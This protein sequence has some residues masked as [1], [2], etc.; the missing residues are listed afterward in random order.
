MSDKCEWGPHGPDGPCVKTYEW[1]DI[2]HPVP[3][4]KEYKGNENLTLDDEHWCPP[5]DHGRHTCPPKNCGCET[6]SYFSCRFTDVLK[7]YLDMAEKY[8]NATSYQERK[9]CEEEMRELKAKLDMIWKQLD[10]RLDQN[11]SELRYLSQKVT[12][13]IGRFQTMANAFADLEKAVEEVNLLDYTDY[14]TK[15]EIDTM[16]PKLSVSG[17]TLLVRYE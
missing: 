7:D 5:R 17:N 16:V 9:S 6:H 11:D 3:Y 13:Y 2:Y 8:I 12:Y 15:S 4:G 10:H 1:P 14:Y